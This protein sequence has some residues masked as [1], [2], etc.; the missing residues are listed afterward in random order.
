MQEMEKEMQIAQDQIS[1]RREEQERAI[2]SVRRLERSIIISY[3]Y[4]VLALLSV[5]SKWSACGPADA[6]AN[7]PSLASVKSRMVLPFWYRLTKVFLE[8]GC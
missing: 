8:K 5:W 4:E 3:Y 1:A 7:P 2:Q 6:T